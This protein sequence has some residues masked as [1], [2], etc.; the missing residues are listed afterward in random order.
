MNEE[1]REMEGTLQRDFK[2]SRRRTKIWVSSGLLLRVDKRILTDNLRYL[3]PPSSGPWRTT[4]HTRR[5]PGIPTSHKP[6]FPSETY[7][8]T[9]HHLFCRKLKELSRF[10]AASEQVSYSRVITHEER[11]IRSRLTRTPTPPPA[12]DAVY[13]TSVLCYL[14]HTGIFSLPETEQWQIIYLTI[15]K[16]QWISCQCSC[17]W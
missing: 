10:N 14:W 16:L 9:H 7:S 2:F 4:H 11:R 13:Y 17:P 15:L 12:C 1:R 6:V 3:L 8:A 5:Q